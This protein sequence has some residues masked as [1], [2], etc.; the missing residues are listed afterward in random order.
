MLDESSPNVVAWDVKR[1]PKAP[2]YDGRRGEAFADWERHLVAGIAS[3]GDA[4]CALEDTL[5]GNDPGGDAPGA[6]PAGGAAM[7]ARRVKRLR[8]LYGILYRHVENADLRLMAAGLNRDGRHS[9]GSC[10]SVSA[11]NQ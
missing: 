6:P 2:P 9:S 4:D 10:S 5:Y 7:H 1:Y 11:V 8:E 3:D